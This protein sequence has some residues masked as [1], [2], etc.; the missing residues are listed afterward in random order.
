METKDETDE[1]ITIHFPIKKEDYERSPSLVKRVIDYKIEKEQKQLENE[2]HSCLT[3]RKTDRRLLS[4]ISKLLIS[5]G[6][7]SFSCVQIIRA[8]PCDSNL[9]LYS[10]LI[11]FVIGS[12]LGNGEPKPSL[13]PLK[14]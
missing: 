1:N 4:Y 11:T 10:S 14:K 5:I 3:G 7:L 2:W 13:T 8:G 12:Y 6:V 9:P